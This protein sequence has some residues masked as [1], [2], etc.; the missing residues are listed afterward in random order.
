M[1]AFNLSVRREPSSPRTRSSRPSPWLPR[2]RARSGSMTPLASCCSDSLRAGGFGSRLIWDPVSP[3]SLCRTS[4]S[5]KR[6]ICTRQTK[7]DKA[8][9]FSAK[10]SSGLRA[11]SVCWAAI[12][13]HGV[14]LHWQSGRTGRSPWRIPIAPR[15]RCSPQGRAHD[16]G[17]RGGIAPRVCRLIASP[18]VAGRG[19]GPPHR[20]DPPR[21]RPVRKRHTRLRL[22]GSPVTLASF[23]PGGFAPRGARGSARE[24]GG[25][26]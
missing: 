25:D 19:L 1:T 16:S 13:F 23:P 18:R 7:R 6:A 2:L 8:S 3:P 21:R 10:E 11:R 24:R 17:P 12:G 26:G 22:F 14:L 20:R 5:I 15:S 9:R 4:P